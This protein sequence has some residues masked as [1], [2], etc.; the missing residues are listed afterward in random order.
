M[1]ILLGLSGSALLA[2]FIPVVMLGEE[3][4]RLAELGSARAKGEEFSM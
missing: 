4:E 2:F 1:C 3:L